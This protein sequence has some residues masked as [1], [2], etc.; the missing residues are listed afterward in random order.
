MKRLIKIIIILVV[1]LVAAA[2]VLTL[3]L[4]KGIQRAVEV[5][6]PRIT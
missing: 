2:I 5:V 4:D 6:G 3:F 1:L